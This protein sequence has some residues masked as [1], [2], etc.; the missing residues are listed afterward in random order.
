MLAMPFKVQRHAEPIPGYK[1]LERL[2]GGGFGEVWKAEAPGG[3]LKAI[4]FVY[5]DLEQA[6]GDEG[7]RAEQELKALSRVKTVRHPYILSL[8]RYDVIDGQL[9]ITMELADRNLW[10]R[11][12]ECREEGLLGIPRDELLRYM[13]ETAEALD[14]MNQEYRLQHLDIKPQNLFLVHNHVKVADFGLVKDLQGMSA[15][16]TGGVTP[17]YAAPE[18]FEGRISRFC[19]QYSLAIVYQE[20]LTGKRPYVAANVHQIILLHLQGTPDLA[21]LPPSDREAIGRALSKVS[22]Q[23]FPCCTDLVR[24]LRRTSTPDTMPAPEPELA[25]ADVPAPEDQVAESTDEAVYPEKGAITVRFGATQG[26]EFL[27]G[28]AALKPDG[29]SENDVTGST[30]PPLLEGEGDLFPA[31]VVGLGGTGLGILRQLRRELVKRFGSVD[32]LPQLRLLY[33]D[34][35]TEALQEAVTPREGAALDRGEVLVARL[36]RAPYYL[37]P[38][39]GRLPI[40]GWFDTAMLYRIQRQQATGGLRALG[41]LAFFGNYRTIAHRLEEELHACTHPNAL[42]AAVSRTGLQ[43]RSN[44]PRVYV[45]AGLAGGTGSGM[46]LDLAYVLRDRLR[47][48]GHAEPDVVGLFVLPAA[49]P[50]PARKVALGNAYAALTEW[51]HFSAPQSTFLAHYDDQ[52]SL[53][54]DSGSPFGRCFLL[55]PRAENRDGEDWVGLAG[56]MLAHDLTT[57][58][59]RAADSRRLGSTGP[60]CQ[61]FG[62]HRMCWPRR[63]LLEL[64]AHRYC[65]ELVQRWMAKD[66]SESAQAVV[67]DLLQPHWDQGEL[68]GDVLLERFQTPCRQAV[69]QDPKAA[70]AFFTDPLRPKSGRVADLNPGILSETLRKLEETLGRPAENSLGYRPGTLEELLRTESETLVAALQGRLGQVSRQLIEQPSLRLAGAEDAARCFIAGAEQ[71]LKRYEPQYADVAEKTVKVHQRLHFLMKNFQEI[72]KLGRRAGPVVDELMDLFHYYPQWRYEALLLKAVVLTFT[73]LRDYF[74]DQLRELGFRRA[75]LA[76]LHQSLAAS[77]GQELLEQTAIE[78]Y[79]LP[80]GCHNL[81][82]AAEQLFPPAAAAEVEALERRIQDLIGRQFTSLEHFCTTSGNVLKPMETALLGE[83]AAFL[84]TRLADTTVEAAIRSRHASDAEATDSLR[85]AFDRAAAPLK[86]HTPSPENEINLAV[87]PRSFEASSLRDQLRQAVPQA[88]WIPSPSDDELLFYRE[89]SHVHIHELEQM[90]PLGKEAYQQMAAVPHLTPHN[91]TDILDWS[92]T[93]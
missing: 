91:R 67:R 30:L 66:T 80:A 14:L 6:T 51:R 40:D 72:V 77:T 63:A 25:T 38:R 60:A 56:Q 2:G 12:K 48:A 86:P 71:G 58:L 79:L 23:R 50:N 27:T 76:E 41:R 36:N 42:A 19:D 5:G 4:K 3:I 1:L 44:R 89:V 85:Q 43:P 57:P 32:A 87:L 46:F 31:L 17:V 16:V 37:H 7:Q 64:A 24:T 82:E 26:R 52:E 20:L 11:F 34:T 8:E 59:G 22:D 13:E 78:S 73:S 62:L 93:D 88:T 21:P 65:Q 74:S 75:R 53:L 39:N 83:V 49:D 15:S 92:T 10:D 61:T 68:S 9:L 33:L 84:E 69:G 29:A 45:V 81:K 18:T 47:Q 55:G 90:G 70:F 28:L 35:D 54:T